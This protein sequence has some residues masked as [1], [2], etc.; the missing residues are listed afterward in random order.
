MNNYL[1]GNI[2][3]FMARIYMRLHGYSVICRHFVSK[4]GS[5]AGEIDFIARRFN[6]LVF[7]EVKERA[8]YASAAYA[9]SAKQQQRLRIGAE[10]FIKHH[11]QFKNL[12]LRFDAILIVFPCRIYHLTNILPKG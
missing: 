11:P 6:T 2:A 7:V 5:G 1:R 8:D 12:D 4:R 10:N 3:E 9:I